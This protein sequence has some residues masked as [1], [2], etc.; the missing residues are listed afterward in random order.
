MRFSQEM[1]S[2]CRPQTIGQCEVVHNAA[3]GARGHSRTI[4]DYYDYNV[5]YKT[6]KVQL[7]HTFSHIVRYGWRNLPCPRRHRLFD[8]CRGSACV[9]SALPCAVRSGIDQCLD[10]PLDVL[11]Q[12]R[13]AAHDFGSNQRAF[14][15]CALS[16]A[17]HCRIDLKLSC[18]QGGC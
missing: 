8:T 9:P 3:L 16:L 7:S 18:Y 13:P 10:G 1:R 5:R 12:S 4:R 6:C 17:L 14:R 15:H 2:F 11:W